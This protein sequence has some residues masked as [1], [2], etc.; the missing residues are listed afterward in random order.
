MQR[1]IFIM[2]ALCGL[3]TGILSGLIWVAIS[4]VNW[5]G[6]L[7]ICLIF[8]INACLGGIIAASIHSKF[9]RCPITLA[10]YVGHTLPLGIYLLFAYFE[11]DAS[12]E[13]WYL[14]FLVGG[15]I[16]SLI[17][18]AICRYFLTKY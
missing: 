4:G 9:S 3:C 11:A 13:A 17:P 18:V 2:S 1:K 16:I 12:M 7:V 15:F 5:L 6:V 8:L 10:L 14:L